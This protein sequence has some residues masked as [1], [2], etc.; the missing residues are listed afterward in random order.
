MEF[1]ASVAVPQVLFRNLRTAVFGIEFMS[2]SVLQER[3][4]PSQKLCLAINTEYYDMVKKNNI[5]YSYCYRCDS[6]G[7][8]L[9]NA[10]S[11]RVYIDR[12]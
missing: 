7:R 12:I 6:C 9:N 11:P 3:Q 8:L 10:D 2:D 5:M 4:F 1:P